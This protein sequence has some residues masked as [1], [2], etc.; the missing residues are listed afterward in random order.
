MDHGTDRLGRAIW[1]KRSRLRW[2]GHLNRMQISDLKKTSYLPVRINLIFVPHTTYI[3][4]SYEKEDFWT[5][6]PMGTCCGTAPLHV[7]LH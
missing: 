3:N 4:V 5:I 2:F 6:S 1:V 7:I